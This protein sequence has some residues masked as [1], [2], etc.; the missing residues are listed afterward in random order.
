MHTL[1]ITSRLLVFF[2][3]LE[4]V[5]TKNQHRMKTKAFFFSLLLAGINMCIAQKVIVQSNVESLSNLSA[6]ATTC[7]DHVNLGAQ[8]GQPTLAF[9]ASDLR[10]SSTGKT[11]AFKDVKGSPYLVANFE[12][13]TIYADDQ[14]IGTYYARYNAYAQEIELKKTTLEEEPYVSLRKDEKFRIVFDDK[15]IRYITFI[16]DKGRKQGDYLISITEGDRYTL[17]K[18]YK[19]NFVEGKEAENSMVN[20]IPNRFTNTTEF[21]VKDAGTNLISYVPTKRSK[22]IALFKDSDKIQI[23]T[24]IK[25][26]GLNIKQEQDLI[27]LFNFANTLQEDYASKGK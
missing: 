16:D 23:T 20:A 9:A 11:I 25:K 12:K 15:E 21:Y 8:G 27:T 3:Y 18:R 10:A 19:V 2:L 6:L 4:E 24:A 13:S 7:G 26:K 17:H 14:R 5:T 22:L 1:F